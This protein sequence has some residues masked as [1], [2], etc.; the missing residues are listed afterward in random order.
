MKRMTLKWTH[1]VTF[2]GVII[3]VSLAYI[4]GLYTPTPM[5]DYQ[6]H[7]FDEV[8]G[9]LIDY[10]YSN[11]TEEQLWEGAILGMI[12]ALDDPFTNYFDA[13]AYERFREGQSESFVGIGITVENVSEQVVIRS[14]FPSSPAE[15]AGLMA[16]D[17]ITHVD[18]TDYRERSFIE[19]T[20]IL[21]GEAGS[22]VE[23]GYRRGGN[24][25]IYYTSMERRVI[26]NPSVTAELL[27]NSIAVIHVHT[28]GS[29]TADLFKDWLEYFEEEIGIEGLIIDLRDNGGGGSDALLEILDI[30]LSRDTHDKPF[31]T[32]E[33]ISISGVE[34][35]P[36]Y[37]SNSDRK[38]YP[39][40]VLVNHYSASAS[41]VFATAMD[42]YGGYTTY[43]TT[44]YGKG[45]FQSSIGL[46]TKSGDYLHLT[47]GRWLTSDGNWVNE[48]PGYEPIVTVE[49]DALF[50]M[51]LLYLRENEE[52]VEDE[53]DDMIARAQTILNLLGH[54]LRTDG[55]FDKVTQ[56]ILSVYQA[57]KSL[58]ITGTLNAETANALSQELLSMRSDLNNDLQLQAAYLALRDE[59]ND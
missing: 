10:H 44:T 42:E 17:V 26:D 2:F 59:L 19:T 21:R 39:I 51:P 32:F 30:F 16:G 15:E 12:R 35:N 13:E 14:V 31:Y 37:G 46:R 40:A 18:G 41:E 6:D 43:G 48:G 5:E 22:T 57:S 11:P 8:F 25:T 33:T 45:T 24:T 38:P 23:V 52:F 58:T 53:V 3:A 50:T 36:V 9:H 49:Q 1:Y 56:D 28:F 55:Y 47:L 20:A 29:D 54:T 27:D 34:T 4:I 7:T